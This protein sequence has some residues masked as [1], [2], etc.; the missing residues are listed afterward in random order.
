M[1]AAFR[2]FHRNLVF[3]E[4]GM[5]SEEPWVGIAAVAAHRVRGLFRS[6]LSEVDEWVQRRKPLVTQP[7][8]TAE[9]KW[10]RPWR[11]GA[12]AATGL[13][14]GVPSCARYGPLPVGARMAQGHRSA[15]LKVIASKGRTCTGSS[16]FA[17][18]INTHSPS[19]SSNASRVRSTGSTSHRCATPSRA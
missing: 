13:M 1:P 8:S 18:A 19:R 7:E 14:K 15:R 2:R 5:A 9:V 4:W 6:R 17:V 12:E 10:T 16:S 11:R 3:C